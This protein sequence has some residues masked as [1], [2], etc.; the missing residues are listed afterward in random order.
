MD[1]TARDLAS[2]LEE[3]DGRIVTMADGRRMVVRSAGQVVERPMSLAQSLLYM[4]T[5]PTVAYLL[6][7]GGLLGLEINFDLRGLYSLECSSAVA[8]SSWRSSASAPYP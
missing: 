7:M 1:L 2:L 3:V 5:D 8:R 4:L 6:L